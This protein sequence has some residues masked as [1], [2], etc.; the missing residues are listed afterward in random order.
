MSAE[1]LYEDL[2]SGWRVAPADSPAAKSI[3][4]DDSQWTAIDLPTDL[5][6]Y[7]P[8]QT[9]WVWI[10]RSISID[11]TAGN[12]SIYL[13]QMSGKALVFLNGIEAKPLRQITDGPVFY[14]LPA[15][16]TP[17][18]AILS[19]QVEL[20]NGLSTGPTQNPILLTDLKKGLK[21]YYFNGI[22]PLSLALL[23]A[24]I[25]LFLFALSRQLSNQRPTY[26]QAAYFYL[27][28]GLIGFGSSV[29][30]LA[31]LPLLL[32]NVLDQFFKSLAI[33]LPV[34]IL[35][36]LRSV[37]N[38]K[39][40]QLQHLIFK[41]ALPSASFFA[42]LHFALSIIGFERTALWVYYL[43]LI[44][45]IPL[46]A[47]IFLI[48]LR[49]T[50]RKM[51]P[52]GF[53][54]LAGLVYFIYAGFT[55][56]LTGSF[57]QDGSAI[58]S[59]LYAPAVLVPFGITIGSLFLSERQV[60]LHTKQVS[61][62]KDEI[63]QSKLFSHISEALD[64]PIRSII[65]SIT[66]EMSSD[67]KKQTLQ[68]LKI[69]ENRLDDILELGRLELLDEVEATVAIP[70]LDFLSAILP[71]TGISH[72][73]H[74]DSDLMIDTSL[75]LVNSAIIRLI[76]FPGFQ[77]FDHIDLIITED[78]NDRLHFRFLMHHRDRKQLRR[79]QDIVLN[80]LPDSEGLWIEWQIIN[81]TIRLLS[82][83]LTAKVL[84]GK[85]LNLDMSLP[86]FHEKREKSDGPAPLT[87]TLLH[88]EDSTAVITKE[89]T[90]RDRIRQLLQKEIA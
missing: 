87:L 47:A 44:I 78:L 40:D 42:A 60:Q 33:L 11:P 66:P 14:L 3:E 9:G 2:S 17:G 31:S 15:I 50:A 73:V 51:E 13:G 26:R 64:A 83:K 27:I 28:V 63:I 30:V 7:A 53:V 71:G 76:R 74:V 82:G 39:D 35:F 61:S 37:L 58:T 8:N 89:L 52:T 34:P 25:G 29:A 1:I 62:L 22:A 24:G 86:G 75:E 49:Q 38:R 16:D 84:A 72:T 56:L 23:Y 5:A 36:Y 59:I 18:S 10:R 20:R 55:S 43:W 32:S 88:T 65:E 80:R 19:I 41:L 46:W 77:T 70:A 21:E 69:Y 45:L 4:T 57:F 6:D 81:E 68:Q 54:L 90:W 85:Y 67:E 12:Y 79:I 48:I